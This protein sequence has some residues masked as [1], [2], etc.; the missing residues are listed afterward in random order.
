VEPERSFE[1]FPIDLAFHGMKGLRFF[2]EHSIQKFL[3]LVGAYS[4][5][6]Y[7]AEKAKNL[8]LGF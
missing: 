4:Q 1:S 7:L 2:R 5:I 8:S 6:I 3:H